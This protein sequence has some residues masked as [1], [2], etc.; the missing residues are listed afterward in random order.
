[1]TLEQARTIQAGDYLMPARTAAPFEPLRVTEVHQSPT[2]RY[3]YVR[4]HGLAEVTAM[5]GGW[6]DARA[7]AFAP[8]G[9][10]YN[11][12]RHRY[13]RLNKEKQVIAAVTVAELT[14]RWRRELEEGQHHV[15]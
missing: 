1:M 8:T 4:L 3:V 7:F 2:G 15:P 9:M 5:A 13:E 6:C 12:A 14:A 10:K 11:H